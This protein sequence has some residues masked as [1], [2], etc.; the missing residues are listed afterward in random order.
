MNGHSFESFEVHSANRA[1]FEACR[2]VARRDYSGPRPVVLLGDAGTGKSHLL[3]SIVRETRAA[4]TRIGLGLVLPGQFPDAVRNLV[5]NPA[6]VRK[7]RP[8]LL[9]VDELERFQENAPDLEAVV[10]LF[11]ENGHDIVFATRTPPERITALSKGLRA[12]LEEAN[13]LQ[14]QAHAPQPFAEPA[15]LGDEVARLMDELEQLR[16]ERDALLE[17]SRRHETETARLA[18]ALEEQTGHDAAATEAAAEK[19]AEAETLR[20]QL[21]TA[22]AAAIED[23]R[24]LEALAARLEAHIETHAARETAAYEETVRLVERLSAVSAAATLFGKEDLAEELAAVRTC[25]AAVNAQWEADRKRFARELEAARGEAAQLSELAETARVEK[26]RLQVALDGARGRLSALEFELEKTRKSQAL[27]NAEM[28]A[29]RHEAATQ[30]ASANIQAGEMEHRILS[31][32]A[33]LARLPRDGAA[34]GEETAK[35]TEELSRA[36]AAFRA[37]AARQAAFNASVAAAP[38]EEDE[39]QTRLFE[40]DAPPAPPHPLPG[41]G[42]GLRQ[43]VERALSETPEDGAEES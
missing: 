26:G 39:R 18:E 9:L 33:A 31:L 6:P 16:I 7:G 38:V 22:R 10:K 27:Q 29:L 36:A 13:T 25:A 41:G 24:K 34:N 11:L 2:A 14:V 21:E 37:L 8:A 5:G 17:Q 43:M 1:A 28:E 20:A 35:V 19:E 4:K 3:W 12:V 23:A 40:D 15:S 30:V 32:E 42:E